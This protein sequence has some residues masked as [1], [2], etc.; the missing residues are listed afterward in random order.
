MSEHGSGL[1]HIASRPP[2]Y[3]ICVPFIYVFRMLI[4]RLTTTIWVKKKKKKRKERSMTKIQYAQ[5]WAHKTILDIYFSHTR[6]SDFVELCGCASQR[7]ETGIKSRIFWK[8]NYMCLFCFTRFVLGEVTRTAVR[9][10][11]NGYETREKEKQGKSRRKILLNDSIWATHRVLLFLPF[12]S[13][14]YFIIGYWMGI[15][16]WT[17]E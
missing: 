9:R 6:I 2:V 7:R 13:Q 17:K 16:I 10:L 11:N 1:R 12:G 14:I 5:R 8:K 3:L 15:G 4:R